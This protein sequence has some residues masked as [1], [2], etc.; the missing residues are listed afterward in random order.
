MWQIDA[1]V[2]YKTK[3]HNSAWWWILILTVQLLGEWGRWLGQKLI[4]LLNDP[5]STLKFNFVFL[6]SLSL[7]EWGCYRSLC[8]WGGGT[9]RPWMGCQL[10]W[11]AIWVIVGLVPYHPT[12]RKNN[13]VPVNLILCPSLH[14]WYTSNLRQSSSFEQSDFIWYRFQKTKLDLTSQMT[15]YNS[16]AFKGIFRSANI[17]QQWK[18]SFQ[19]A[20]N[21]RRAEF[22]TIPSLERNNSLQGKPQEQKTEGF[23]KGVFN[24]SAGWLESR[25]QIK[26]WNINSHIT[27]LQREI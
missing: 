23:F 15:L 10:V 12:A 16:Q 18:F 3:M 2:V 26:Y 19:T 14:L 8:W 6:P 11:G 21:N 24:I 5:V 7:S 13:G 27:P 20:E 22:S 17:W 25:P 1:W 9:V 4:D